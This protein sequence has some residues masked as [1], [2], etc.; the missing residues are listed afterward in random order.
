MLTSYKLLSTQM[1]DFNFACVVPRPIDK[2]YI[3]GHASKVKTPTKISVAVRLSKKLERA[4]YNSARA[5]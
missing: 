3:R 1:A 4:N 5:C 2:I